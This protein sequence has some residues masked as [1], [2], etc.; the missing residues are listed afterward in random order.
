[1]KYSTRKCTT[2]PTKIKVGRIHI[3]NPRNGGKWFFDSDEGVL[4]DL[5]KDGIRQS[6]KGAS[7]WFC[8]HCWEVFSG[9]N[10][11]VVTRIYIP[12]N[13]KELKGR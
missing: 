11:K 13:I 4:F 1:M 8:N 5:N 3:G 9:C 7:H 12:K 2:C 10:P 6:N